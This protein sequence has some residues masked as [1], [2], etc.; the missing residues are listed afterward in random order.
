MTT[1]DP[2]GASSPL[3]GHPPA[4]SRRRVRAAVDGHR[5]TTFELFFDLVFV[6]ATTQV[7]AHIV[8]THSA[9]GVVQGT[10]ILGLLWWAWSSYAWLGNQA[11]ADV[12]PIRLG[13]VGAMI[14]VFIVAL[15]IPEAWHDESGGL[16]AGTVLA[17]AYIAIRVIHEILYF[18]A[19]EGD[20]ALRRQLGLNL[21]PLFGGGTLLLVGALAV[22]D[23]AQTAVW[24]AALA[25]DWALT[26]LTSVRGRG[27]RINS[28]SHWVERHGLVVILALGESVVAIGVG[29]AAEP[30]DWELLVGASLGITLAAALWWL[31]FDV[32]ADAAEQALHRRDDP[33]RAAIESYTYL[34]FLSIFGI[35]VTAVGVEGA[36]AHA[37]ER[38][39]LGAFSAGC[40]TLGPAIYLAGH[41]LSWIRLDG[42]VKTQ[43]VATIA[44]LVAL[45]P[46]AAA[47]TALL[48]LTIVVAVPIALVV[49]ETAKY[50]ELRAAIQDARP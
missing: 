47:T 30:L 17:V 26:Y 24:A 28:I 49:V 50:S 11:H 41:V 18:V 39:P 45:W 22:E 48:S 16:H 29:A 19:A 31:Y 46:V 27:W 36:L 35:V 3:Q 9:M 6:F 5:V 21:L 1:A 13:M 12:G 7:T 20:E 34:H 23:G 38:D 37:T 10:V 33:V 25:V 4:P 14:S 43:R 42:T 8:H 32:S 2:E 40:L 15:A 44:V